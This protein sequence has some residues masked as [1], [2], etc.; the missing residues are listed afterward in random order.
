M[1]YSTTLWLCALKHLQGNAPRT[2]AQCACQ[3]GGVKA[4]ETE[5]RPRSSI[6]RDASTGDARPDDAPRVFEVGNPKPPFELARLPPYTSVLTLA[7]SSIEVVL[8][9]T[10]TVT[11]TPDARFW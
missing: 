6:R 2:R 5:Y 8:C 1:L 4:A 10:Q 9:S 3:S 11:K 7:T